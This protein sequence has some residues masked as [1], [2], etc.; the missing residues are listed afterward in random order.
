MTSIGDAG[1]DKMPAAFA[2]REDKRRG[3]KDSEASSVGPSTCM[4]G[5]VRFELCALSSLWSLNNESLRL[6]ERVRSENDSLRD[7]VLFGVRGIE[8]SDLMNAAVSCAPR[9][10]LDFGLCIRFPELELVRRVGC[11]GRLSATACPE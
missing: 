10:E 2:L 9:D 11:S 3:V 4:P 5:V 6:T 8:S 7:E 1:V